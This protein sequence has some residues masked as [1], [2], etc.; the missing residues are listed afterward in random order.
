MWSPDA[1][2][3]SRTLKVAVST[4]TPA[5]PVEGSGVGGS[6]GRGVGGVTGVT[7][8]SVL[9]SGKFRIVS[10][11]VN[12]S[13]WSN[14][15]SYVVLSMYSD[16]GPLRWLYFV[17]LA[18]FYALALVCNLLLLF[19]IL[20]DRSLRQPMYVF[21]VSLFLNDVLGSTGI[22]PFL[23]SELLRDEH[24]LSH[25]LCFLQIFLVYQ[26]ANTAVLTLAAMSYDRFVAICF[27]LQYHTRLSPRAALRMVTGIWAFVVLEV[28]FMVSLSAPLRLCGTHVSKV[29]CDNYSVV[30]LAC[31]DTTLNNVY[32]LLYTCLMLL[33]VPAL[34]LYSYVRIIRVCVSSSSARRKALGTCAPHLAS[35]LN[36]A[37][38][39]FFEVVQSRFNMEAVSDTVRVFMSLYFLVCTPIFNPLIY[40]LNLST[41]RSS[42]RRLLQ[43]RQRSR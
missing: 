32:G 40:G 23:L 43:R 20:V 8:P 21:L 14:S 2:T 39:C 10:L 22:F 34:I 17:V 6:G 26:Y 18:C 41:V 28:G 5:A 25:S 9:D 24:V 35:F 12:M 19:V 15:S 31:G 7:P 38:G 13:F 37:F 29:Y 4:N 27:P 36:L 3:E 42:C 33:S 1:L 16:S 30:K 11:G